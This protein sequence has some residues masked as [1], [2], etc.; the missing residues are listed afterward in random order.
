M[1]DFDR[2]TQLQRAA[3]AVRLVVTD[4]DGV[5]TPDTLMLAVVEAEAKKAFSLSEAGSTIRLVECDADGNPT[6]WIRC[7]AHGLDGRIEGYRFYTRDGIAVKECLRHGIPVMFMSGRNSPAVCQRAIDLGAKYF[8]GVADKVAVLEDALKTLHLG[9]N[10]V[11]F[12]G[13]DIQDLS[14]LRRVGFS[15]VPSDAVPEALCDATYVARSKGGEGVVRE[16]IEIV[17]KAQGY[18]DKIVARERTLG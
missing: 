13:N 15:A 7:F 14:L 16:V 2:F 8:L 12:I 1:N 10:Q 3:Q 4:V 18:W 17:L 5:H 6:D 9:W 11:L